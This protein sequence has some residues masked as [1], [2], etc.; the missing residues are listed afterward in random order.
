M[1]VALL[2]R[3]FNADNAGIG[4]YSKNLLRELLERGYELDLFNTSFKGRIGYFLYTSLEL[5]FKLF[6]HDADVYHALTPLESIWTPKDKTVTTFHD[7]IPWLYR[8]EETWYFSGMA[9]W[10]YRIFGS[11]WFELAAKRAL[12]SK[13]IICNSE[14]TKAEVIKYLNVPEEKITVTRLG[15]SEDLK[16]IGTNHEGYTVGTLSYLDPRKRIDILIRAFKKIDDAKAVLRIGG[17]K[18]E[19]Y[20]RLRKIAGNDKRIRFEGYIPNE[21]LPKF[22]NSLDVFVLPSKLEGYGLPFVEAMA[23]KV[24]VV[25][26]E[27]A[28]IPSDVKNRTHV[29]SEGDLARV[30]ERRKFDC[31]IGANLEFAKRHKW[32]DL[33]DKTEAVYKEVIG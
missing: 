31:D 24:P 25:S 10:F 7:L 6:S 16:P 15:I 14:Q 18:G 12:K 23:C 21:D 19:D 30:L 20:P 1:K 8:K 13:R 29:A 28:L 22:Y 17:K 26:L 5:S 11:K 9:G 4:V 32:G 3:F 33:T 27:D 2:T